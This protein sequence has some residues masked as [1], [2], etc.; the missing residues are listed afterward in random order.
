MYTIGLYVILTGG[1]VVRTKD[2]AV[3]ADGHTIRVSK[4]VFD[5]LN[6][7]ILELPFR[8]GVRSFDGAVGWMFDN[9][10]V[11]E[12]VAKARA[13]ALNVLNEETRKIG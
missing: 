4:R 11:A 7:L 2:G 6:R 3:K 10:Q 8:E 12:G 1:G 5:R 9:L 13:H